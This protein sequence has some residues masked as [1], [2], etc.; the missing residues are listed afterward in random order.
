MTRRLIMTILLTAATLGTGAQLSHA[1]PLGQHGGTTV[2]A[3]VSTAPD[4]PQR[5][6]TWGP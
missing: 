4:S 2:A 6:V 1:E 3:P 5:D